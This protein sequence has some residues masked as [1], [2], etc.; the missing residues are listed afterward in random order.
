MF[1]ELPTGQ[2]AIY[3]LINLESNSIDSFSSGI[4]LSH[5]WNNL[6]LLRFDKS[7]QA[8]PDGLQR[9]YWCSQGKDVDSSVY[10]SQTLNGPSISITFK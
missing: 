10:L 5:H 2:P 4:S 1:E 8:Y 3:S 6:L 7:M 9:S